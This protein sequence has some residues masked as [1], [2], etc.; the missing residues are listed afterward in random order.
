M[1]IV[2]WIGNKP[3]QRALANKI[4]DIYPLAGLVVESRPTKSK[5]TF[6]KII[7]KLFL[8]PIS[9]A[10]KNMQAYYSNLYANYPNVKRL[11]TQNINSEESFNFTNEINPDLIIV[12]GTRLIK[13]K[14]LSINPSI[15]ILNLHTGISPYVKGGP[16]S[17]NWCIANKELHLIGNTI[18][19][20]DIGVDTGNIVTTEIT[21]FTGDESLTQVHIKVMEHGHKLYLKAIDMLAKGIK[22][23]VD[24]DS[25][26]KGATYTNKQWGLKQKISL[27]FNFM[28]FRKDIKSANYAKQREKVIT[29]KI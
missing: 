24:Q 17:T 1:K 18:M 11:N 14:M 8:F 26:G 22:S 23:N 13:E 4:H 15:G 7:E 3:N 2:L 21:D 12:S 16:N 5:I 19:W 6:G 10:W 9:N 27:I 29:I 20:I 28:S 25:I